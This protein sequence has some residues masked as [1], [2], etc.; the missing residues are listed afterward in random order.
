MQ[1]TVCRMHVQYMIGELRQ[2]NATCDDKYLCSC[3]YM[4]LPVHD[5]IPVRRRAGERGMGKSA[6]LPPWQGHVPLLPQSW[7]RRHRQCRERLQGWGGD[8]EHSH[9]LE[10]YTAPYMYTGLA[11]QSH[12]G[13]PH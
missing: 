13:S 6:P 4:Y 7:Q 1:C 8:G 9:R 5:C 10:L 2:P 12:C 3:I 11:Y